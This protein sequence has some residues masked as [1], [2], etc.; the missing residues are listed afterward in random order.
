MDLLV[1]LDTTCIIQLDTEAD[2]LAEVAEHC[3]VK[4]DAVADGLSAHGP[5]LA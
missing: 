5:F 4:M 1:W 2:G 3:L